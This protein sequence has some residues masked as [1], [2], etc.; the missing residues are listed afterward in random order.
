MTFS[1]GLMNELVFWG[2]VVTFG[3]YRLKRYLQHRDE[4]RLA[5]HARKVAYRHTE[6]PEARGKVH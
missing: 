4:Q 1:G 2:I 3:A 5:L 6:V